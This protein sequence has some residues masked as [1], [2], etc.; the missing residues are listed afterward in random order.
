MAESMDRRNHQSHTA[1]EDPD[2]SRATRSAWLWGTVVVAFLILQLVIGGLAFNLATGDPSVAVVPDYH[3][4][5]LNWD[6]EL[7]RRKRSDQLGWKSA[8]RWGDTSSETDRRELAIEV[9]DSDGN[10]VSGGEASVRFYHHA[11]GVDVATTV[12]QELSPGKYAA[13]LPMAK[14]GLWE[15]EFSLSRGPDEAYWHQQTI[16]I[17]GNTVVGAA[18]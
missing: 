6:D 11:R 17:G 1:N 2:K 4:R 7:A 16:D 14:P 15:I 9:V 10:P 5:A 8:V 3:E 12:L 18:E 13:E